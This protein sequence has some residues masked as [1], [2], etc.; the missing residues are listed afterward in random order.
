MTAPS[1]R[2]A[3]VFRR[4]WA[5]DLCTHSVP[6][7]QRKVIRHMLACRTPALGGHLWRCDS[8]GRDVGLYNS[9]RD[10]HCPTC[11]GNAREVWLRRRMKEVLP[12]PYFHVV[13]TLPHALNPLMRHN[14]EELIDL[15]F[16]E[17]NA[18]LQEFA[19]DPQWRL[20]GQLGFLAV[21]HTWT[22]TLGEHYHLHCAVPGGAWRSATQT[23]SSARRNWLFRE[24]SL[25]NRFRNRYLRAVL[26]RLQ[27]GSLA[28]PEG[29]TDWAEVC[30]RLARERWIV[31]A[32]QPFAGPP[33]ALEY[34]GRYTHKVAI[35]D[36]R[37][38]AVE[39]GQVTFR[40]RDRK[41][42]DI[43]KEMT[44]SAEAFIGRFLLHILPPGLQ[45]IRFYGW[46]ARNVRT[47]NLKCI[48]QALGIPPPPTPERPDH[49]D[50]PSC[51]HCGK[52]SLQLLSLIPAAR[53]PPRA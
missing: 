25:A 49:P 40:Y 32:K 3:D 38:L 46:R 26:R 51:P 6:A 1:W 28:R 44:L 10:R 41:A 35:G 48:R 37:I 23:W 47:H 20:E 12:V 34:L 42:G 33:Q 9:C 19:R 11:Q 50:A 4:Y 16:R 45:K 15:F 30:G 24:E 5:D 13:F 17:V 53:G 43:L 14:R 22:Q 36:Y 27:R 7:F 8:C 21:L 29:G 52:A 18:T 39:E 31:Y 2:V